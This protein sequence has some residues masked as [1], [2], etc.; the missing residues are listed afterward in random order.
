MIEAMAN[1]GFFQGWL[2]LI[3]VRSAKSVKRHCDC[4]LMAAG[5]EEICFVGDGCRCSRSIDWLCAGRL[6][7]PLLQAGTI[8]HGLNRATGSMRA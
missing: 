2:P 5:R 8:A 7:R 4:K 1:R 3:I 6:G